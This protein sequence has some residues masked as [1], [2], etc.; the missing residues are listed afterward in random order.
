MFVHQAG[1]SRCC[2]NVFVRVLAVLSVWQ[3]LSMAVKRHWERHGNVGWLPFGFAESRGNFPCRQLNSVVCQP[4]LALLAA[5]VPTA[6]NHEDYESEP[7]SIAP[8]VNPNSSQRLSVGIHWLMWSFQVVTWISDCRTSWRQAGNR[9]TLKEKGG[10]VSK[11]S[12]YLGNHPE[13][14]TLM[15]SKCQEALNTMMKPFFTELGDSLQNINT[16]LKC[17]W[18]SNLSENTV[19]TLTRP[20]HPI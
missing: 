15:E 14:L 7:Q 4:P 11:L 13:K 20:N 10:S 3:W 19:V 5:I 17:N 8:L 12:V 2:E 16:L 1:F 6:V 9:H 18:K